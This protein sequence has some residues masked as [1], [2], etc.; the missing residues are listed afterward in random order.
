MKRDKNGFI[1][2]E[3][4]FKCPECG[5]IFR[6]SQIDSWAWGRVKLPNGEYFR[7]MRSFGYYPHP[8]DAV[9]CCPECDTEIEI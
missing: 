1:I 2:Q 4:K 8:S 7:D 9:P 5:K 3:R 6:E